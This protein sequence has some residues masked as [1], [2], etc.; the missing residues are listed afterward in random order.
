MLRMTSTKPAA[1]RLRSQFRDSRATPTTTPSSVARTMPMR[2]D[3]QRVEQADEQ[4]ASV[5]VGCRVANRAL[6][7]LETR[8]EIEEVEPERELAARPSTP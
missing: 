1:S 6:G 2:A 3:E 8:H 5:R 4:G 7:D